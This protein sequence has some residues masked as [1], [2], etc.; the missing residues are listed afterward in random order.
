MKK[1]VLSFIISVLIIFCYS[2]P[3]NALNDSSSILKELD[4]ET[5]EYLSALGIDS[6]SGDGIENV[7]LKSV[8]TFLISLVTDRSKRISLIIISVIA[9]IIVS[10]VM[11]SFL[12]G[13]S[14]AKKIL[15]FVSVLCIVTAVIVPLKELIVNAGAVIKTAAIFTDGYIPVLVS[16]I[17][18]SGNPKLAIT[19]NSFAVVLSSFISEISDKIFVPVINM[20]LAFN[21]LTS[22]TFENY[23]HKMFKSVKR[24]III[25]LS[26]ISTVY[27]G[28]L[29][30]QSILAVSSDSLTVRGIR[31]VS[32][33]FIPIVG[34]GVSESVSSVMSSLSIMRNTTGVV[35]IVII[36]LIFLPIILDLLIWHY[37]LQFCSITADMFENND[38]SVMLDEMS[39]VVSLINTVLF[40]VT[41]V[42]II[43]TGVIIV[44]GK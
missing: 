6:E 14:S 37:A 1:V 34:A 41:F 19:Y 10:S 44:M 23:K 32:G 11:G 9:V 29:T 43:S 24:L 26:L 18:A 30:T 36:V 15:N 42:L 39:S 28:L 8:I 31:F 20:L 35:V 3:C 25:I 17:A 13:N 4:G 21:I 33:T 38:I 2:L 22:F 12:E 16:L 7:S 27:T 5:K 40:Y